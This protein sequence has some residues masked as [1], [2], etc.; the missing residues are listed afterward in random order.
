[1]TKLEIIRDLYTSVQKRDTWYVMGQ[2]TITDI[3]RFFSA[4]ILYFCNTGSDVIKGSLVF[5]NKEY[6]GKLNWDNASI[7]DSVTGEISFGNDIVSSR[8]FLVLDKAHLDNINDPSSPNYVAPDETF[9]PFQAQYERTDVVQISDDDYDEIVSMAIGGVFIPDEEFEYTRE[10]ITRLAIAPA[11]REFFKWCPHTR[12]QEFPCTSNV[13]NVIM[14]EDAYCVVGLSLQQFGP[15]SSTIGNP[16]LWSLLAS[17]YL[18]T[19]AGTLT[20]Q[21]MGNAA[22]KTAISNGNTLLLARAAQQGFINYQ[23]RMHYEGP[24]DDDSQGTVTGTPNAR[25]IT[26]YCNTLGAFNVWWGIKTSNFN[27]VEFAQ[28]NN[29]IK[30]CSAK[31]KQLFGQLRRQSK[32]GIPG[33]VDYSYLVAEGKEEEKAIIDELKTL[34]KSA[35]V[36]RGSL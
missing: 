2:N 27:D 5:C 34:V 9:I 32:T 19:N 13:Q 1:M 29:A 28:K 14:P 24:Y 8:F 30:L 18:G 10:D 23:R 12:P 33:Q 15:A 35:G 11:L 6:I 25:Y 36:I 21:Y 7:I 22:P 20:G 26:V 17:P 16:I 3:T 31:V 4:D